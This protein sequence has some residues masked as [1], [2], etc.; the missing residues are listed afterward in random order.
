MARV[1]AEPQFYLSPT[2]LSTKGISHPVFP[3]LYFTRINMSG[4]HFL[5][6]VV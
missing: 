6:R 3:Y 5:S 1:N 2:R 4:T